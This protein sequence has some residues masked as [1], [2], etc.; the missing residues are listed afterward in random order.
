MHVTEPQR[1]VLE[2]LRRLLWTI[3]SAND[4]QDHGSGDEAEVMRKRSCE[5]IR[6]LMAEHPF[7]AEL[8]PKLQWQV[9]SGHI[10]GF[11][12]SVLVDQLEAHVGDT[13]PSK[14]PL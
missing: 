11:G 8:F 13:G 2:T 12:W 4:A 10:L 3:G 14:H 9:E 1:E 6:T 7:L 5:A